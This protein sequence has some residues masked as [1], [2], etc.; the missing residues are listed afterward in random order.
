MM[1][2]EDGQAEQPGGY[3][4]CIKVGGDGMISVGVDPADQEQAEMGE[5]GE[6]YTQ[7][8]SIAEALQSAKEIYANNGQM[9]V[10]GTDE[11]Q[12]MAGYN[13]GA[14]PM[15]MGMPASKVFGDE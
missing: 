8:Q 6:A 11:Q 4:I 2:S 9:P 3:E 14:K 5:A 1:M 15:G 10:Q 7:V 13:K 12:A